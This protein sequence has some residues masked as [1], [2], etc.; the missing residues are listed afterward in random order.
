MDLIAYSDGKKN[1]YEISKII[2]QPL[3]KITSELK[4]L[5]RKKIISIEK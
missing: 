2:K 3:N 5:K 1:L 4:I